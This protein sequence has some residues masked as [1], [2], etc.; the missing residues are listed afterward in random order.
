MLD[1]GA[2]GLALFG[3]GAAGVSLCG[4][5]SAAAGLTEAGLAGADAAAAG[6][7]GADLGGEAFFTAESY[8]QIGGGESSSISPSSRFS[9]GAL[10][11]VL[12][13]RMSLV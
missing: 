5:G 8:C 1:A 12:P 2:A 4:V 6:L 9:W 11:C 10:G 7:A 3:A 13:V